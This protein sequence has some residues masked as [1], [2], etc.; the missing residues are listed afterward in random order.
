MTE[1]F[2]A[3]LQAV[4]KAEDLQ[5]AGTT[6]KHQLD[7][8]RIKFYVECEQELRRSLDQ[9]DQK[10]QPLIPKA[11]DVKAQSNCM[12]EKRTTAERH[13]EEREVNRLRAEIPKMLQRAAYEGKNAI[14]LLSFKKPEV[15]QVYDPLLKELRDNGYKIYFSFA[16]NGMLVETGKPVPG[17]IQIYNLMLKFD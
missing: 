10:Q 2:D 8:L 3:R 15:P 6:V 12:V 17:H 16:S 7:D 1:R 5:L 4:A 11:R 14:T 9:T 13:L